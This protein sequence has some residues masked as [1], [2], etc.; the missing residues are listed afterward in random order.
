MYHSL[1]ETVPKKTD[2]CTY[3]W[4]KW[5]F[6]IKVYVY[7]LKTKAFILRHKHIDSMCFD[8]IIGNLY[9]SFAIRQGFLNNLT[10]YYAI[11]KAFNLKGQCNPEYSLKSKDSNV[12]F[13]S[14]WPDS[15]FVSSS[16]TDS[17]NVSRHSTNFPVPNVC[18]GSSHMQYRVIR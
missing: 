10:E 5:Y 7:N 17:R 16:Q 2:I 13:R 6:I 18:H 8:F 4:D 9:F 3:C 15:V 1:Y 12:N 11:V 14:S